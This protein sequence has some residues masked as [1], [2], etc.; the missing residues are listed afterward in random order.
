MADTVKVGG[1]H[2]NKWVAYGGIGV[3]VVAGVLYFKKKNSSSSSGSATQANAIDPVTGLPVSED[4]QIDPATGLTYLAEAQQY[5]SVSA[6][7]SAVGAG[8]G[9]VSSAGTGYSGLGYGYPTYSPTETSQGAYATN[10]AWAQ[11]VQAALPGITGDSASNVATAVGNY[12]GG[13][14]LTATQANDI[15]VAIAEFGP[16][17]SGNLQIIQAPAASGATA[18]GSATSGGSGAS[19]ATTP[20]GITASSPLS[21]PL[22]NSSLVGA[23]WNGNDSVFDNLS[24]Q[25]GATLGNLYYDLNN[26][27]SN[28]QTN[29]NSTNISFNTP[30]DP[31][32]N[33]FVMPNVVGMKATQAAAAIQA[34]GYM[35]SVGV[36]N[37]SWGG[38]VTSATLPAGFVDVTSD[39]ENIGLN[40]N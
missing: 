30:G 38:T 26:I 27:G 23:N 4:N 19:I 18:T 28:G 25:S 13:L 15:Q 32:S 1:K 10:A 7:E 16:P 35:G 21:T 36:R 37:G 6:A 33:L 20:P 31:R 29:P 8:Y 14:A 12:L 5:G 39:I 9:G 3:V 22:P 24:T 34:A 17:P 11:A 40:T 2:V